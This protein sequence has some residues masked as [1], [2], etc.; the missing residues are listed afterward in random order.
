MGT[1]GTCKAEGCGKEV[2]AKGYCERHYRL[3]KKGKMP[4]PRYKTC[5]A[6]NCR[7][8]RQRRGLCAEHFA[9]QYPGKKALEASESAA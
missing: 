9:Q 1:K 4:K 7:R 5:V 2:R 3:W 6:E 8:P